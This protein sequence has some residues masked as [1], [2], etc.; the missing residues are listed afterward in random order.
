MNCFARIPLWMLC[1]FSG[2]IQIGFE[3]AAAQPSKPGVAPLV[4]SAATD[5]AA[6]PPVKG[7]VTIEFRV[8]PRRVRAHVYHGKKLLGKTPFKIER[9]RDSGPID[10]WVK[11]HGF[12]SVN[13]RAY[14]FKDDKIIIQLT[15]DE[16]AHTLFGY[17]A[18]LVEEE[19][20][21]AGAQSNQTGE[22]SLGAP[23]VKSP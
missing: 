16:E 7:T 21:V 2:G 14:T 23:P 19:V 20:P 13:T 17:K 15:P 4:G 10:V 12:I 11:A 18:P 22:P 9:D 1:I 6:G 5:V 8:E 3:H